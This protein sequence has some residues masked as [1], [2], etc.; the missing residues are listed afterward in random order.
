MSVSDTGITMTVDCGGA[1]PFNAPAS[2]TQYH[3]TSMGFRSML[4]RSDECLH[5]KHCIDRPVQH[6]ANRE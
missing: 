4:G 1:T 3:Y 5:W 6:P 2:V